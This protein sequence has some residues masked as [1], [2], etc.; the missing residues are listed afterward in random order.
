MT[1]DDSVTYGVTDRTKIKLFVL[2]FCTVTILSVRKTAAKTV[3]C[4]E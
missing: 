1:Y 4:M 2:Y 3:N